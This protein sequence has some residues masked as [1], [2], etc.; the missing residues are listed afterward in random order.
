MLVRDKAA[1]H[2]CT[3]LC[4][5]LTKTLNTGTCLHIWW[6]MRLLT[7]SRISGPEYSLALIFRVDKSQ[8]SICGLIWALTSRAGPSM[9]NFSNRL[10]RSF[11][12]PST[13]ARPTWV[14]R[15]PNLS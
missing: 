7:S 13:S 5:K 3:D 4:R 8:P 14:L 12:H 10:E 2:L 1:R 11:F 9:T 15:Y 6:T